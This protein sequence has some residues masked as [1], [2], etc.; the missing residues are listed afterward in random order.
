MRYV[1]CIVLEPIHV[2]YENAPGARG[3][4]SVIPAQAGIQGLTEGGL[5]SNRCAAVA[6]LA[7]QSRPLVRWIPACA[8]MTLLSPVSY[9]LPTGR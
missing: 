6:N 5:A 4:V 8:G 9:S 1:G 2:G 3:Q 7:D